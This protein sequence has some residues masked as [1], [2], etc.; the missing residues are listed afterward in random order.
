MATQTWAQGMWIG[1]W[2]T[3]QKEAWMIQ[4]GSDV[5]T[6][7]RTYRSGHLRDSCFFEV[8]VRV[9]MRSVCPKDVKSM[10]LGQARSNYRRKCAT[11]HENEELKEGI[12]LEP[13]LAL[14]RKKKKE[15]WTDKHR[16][17]ARKLVLVGDQV[18]KR[19]FDF[20]WSGENK[21]QICH[22]EKGKE[23]HRLT[24]FQ[25]GTRS[26][27]RSQRLSESGSKRREPQRRSGSGKKV[28]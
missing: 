12:W 11:K 27:V 13:G 9:D 16:N 1:K 10:C 26:D 5:E 21:C 6:S 17:V 3:E 23:K 24:I 15:G 7:E 22:K 4:I 2:H 28:L 20:G 25:N 14:L 18:Q 19:L 8:Q